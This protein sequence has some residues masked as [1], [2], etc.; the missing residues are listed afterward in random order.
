MIFLIFPELGIKRARLYQIWHPRFERQNQQRINNDTTQKQNSYMK[1]LIWVFLLGWISGIHD[2]L[3]R[4][5]M[6]LN[7]IFHTFIGS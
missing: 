1:I 2:L 3:T 5:K 4:A 7:P 6:W